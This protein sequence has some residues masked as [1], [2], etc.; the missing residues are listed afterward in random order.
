MARSEVPK[1]VDF[2]QV[3]LVLVH[4]Q[5]PGDKGGVKVQPLGGAPHA[6]QVLEHVVEGLALPGIHIVVYESVVHVIP[7]A[8][9]ST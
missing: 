1:S 2:E 9:C 8:I 4:N 6:L 3:A 5:A 7:C